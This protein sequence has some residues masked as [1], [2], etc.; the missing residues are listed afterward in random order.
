MKV[1]FIKLIKLYRKYL[2]PLKKPCCKYYPTCSQYA[3]DAISKYG[4]LKGGFMSFKR[5][6]RCNPF[7]KGGYDPVK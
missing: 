1:I 2:S 6:L 7:S 5:I 3:I 4:A